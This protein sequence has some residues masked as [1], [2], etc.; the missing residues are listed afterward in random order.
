MD[1][2]F[3]SDISKERDKPKEAWWSFEKLAQYISE[4]RLILLRF[5]LKD[6]QVFIQLHESAFH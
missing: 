1:V 2:I 3:I 6:L 5:D 4:G